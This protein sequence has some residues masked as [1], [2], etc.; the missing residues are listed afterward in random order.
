MTFYQTEFDQLELDAL[1]WLQEHKVPVLGICRGCQ[2]LNVFDGGTL[3]QDLPS[4]YPGPV[5]SHNQTALSIDRSTPTH[6]VLIDSGSRLAKL[7]G[8]EVMTNSMHHQSVLEPGPHYRVTARGE[9]G[10]VEAIEHENGLW[11][12]VQW[13][14]ECLLET[15]PVMLE[16]F[17]SFVADCA[18]YHDQK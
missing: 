1:T 2:V 9:D 10:V 16:L 18:A 4:Q 5:G 13:H 6:K 17:R 15:V 12:A 11:L 8:S 3:Y 7:L 14:P